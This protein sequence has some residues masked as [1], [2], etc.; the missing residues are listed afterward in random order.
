MSRTFFRGPRKSLEDRHVAFLG[1]T[2]TYGKFVEYPFTSIVESE[3]GQTCVNFGVMNGGIDVFLNDPVVL[4]A[5][6]SAEATVVQVMG[7]QNLS[8]RFYRVHPRRNDRFV[9][10]STVLRALYNDVDFSEFNFTRHMLGALFT[11]SAEK[12]EIVRE[13]LQQAWLARMKLLIEKIGSPVILL[14]FSNARPDD[15]DWTA[16][17]SG[18]GADPLFVT[19]SMLDWLR[20]L[21]HETVIVRPSA[22]A[23]SAGTEGMVFPMLQAE[24][25]TEMMGVIAHEEAAGVLTRPLHALLTK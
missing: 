2:G 16:R 19:K 24:A 18:L 3:L 4:S 5:C 17:E 11:R 20:P 12:F 8:N 15:G 23:Q 22:E 13:E 7:A 1:G 21:V 10:A 9:V 25:A 14:W 6:Q